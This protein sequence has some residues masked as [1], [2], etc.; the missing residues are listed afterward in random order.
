MRMEKFL[1]TTKYDNLFSRCQLSNKAQV[2]IKYLA[3]FLQMAVL[4]YARYFYVCANE[5]I[6]YL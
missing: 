2:T 1:T 4:L 3:T 5:H 6:H